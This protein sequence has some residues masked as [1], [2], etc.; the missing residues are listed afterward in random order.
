MINHFPVIGIIMGFLLLAFA[1]IRKSEELKRVSLGVVFFIAL[2]AIPVYFTGE[3]TAEVVEKIPG[4]SEEVVEE[5]E[6]IA[7]I[8]LIAVE[9]LGLMAVGGL[10]YFRQSA[11]MPDWFIQVAL[12]LSVITVGLMAWTANSGGQI[13]HPEIQANFNAS[14]SSPVEGYLQ[15]EQKSEKHEDKKD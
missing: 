3:P 13:R 8:A 10:V 12:V 2:I 4:V 15:K 5:H 1:M 9:V 6:E 14:T 7:L 11:S